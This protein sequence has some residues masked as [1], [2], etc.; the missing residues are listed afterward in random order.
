[1]C[2]EGGYPLDEGDNLRGMGIVRISGNECRGMED[3]I[4][5]GSTSISLEIG[6][7]RIFYFSQLLCVLGSS[8][9]IHAEDVG[10]SFVSTNILPFLHKRHKKGT[11]LFVLKKQTNHVCD[12][13]FIY[14]VRCTSIARD[15]LQLLNVKVAIIGS[16]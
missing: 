3:G 13:T 12:G 16:Q 9:D 10:M 2:G 11:N 15:T 7:S 14:S 1:M 5:G 8:F 6:G 4:R